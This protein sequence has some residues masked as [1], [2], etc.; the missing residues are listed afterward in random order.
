MTPQQQSQLISQYLEGGLQEG[1]TESRRVKSK[2]AEE[3]YEI[4]KG[5]YHK[6]IYDHYLEIAK[7]IYAVKQ[8]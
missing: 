6:L 5:Y 3:M 8:K 4:A 7:E 1:S 2:I